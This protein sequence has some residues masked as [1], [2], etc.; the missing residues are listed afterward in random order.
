MI[1][2]FKGHRVPTEQH[3][4]AAIANT[5]KVI[6]DSQV[7]IPTEIEVENAKNWVDANE[8]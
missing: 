2:N 7:T 8:K 5:E 1:R 6:K 3:T 4:T